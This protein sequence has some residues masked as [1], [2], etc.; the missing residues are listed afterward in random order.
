M[1]LIYTQKTSPR[2]RYIS[3][4]LFERILGIPVDFTIK[5]EKKRSSFML[6]C[7]KGCDWKELTFNLN[8][9]ESITVDQ[10]GTGN[11]TDYS[12]DFKILVKNIEDELT[13]YTFTVESLKGTNWLN[14]STLNTKNKAE[15]NQYKY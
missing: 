13:H 5:I 7:T 11:R 15:I 14:R 8:K 4:Q 12:S 6:K 10:F 3:K 2:L 1:L 9:N